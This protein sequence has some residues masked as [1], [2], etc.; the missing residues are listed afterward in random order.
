MLLLGII[1]VSII[2]VMMDIMEAKDRKAN[3]A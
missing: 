2:I 1:D 3:K